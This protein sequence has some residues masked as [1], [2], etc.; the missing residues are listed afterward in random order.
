MTGWLLRRRVERALRMTLAVAGDCWIAPS[1]RV[2][3]DGL[4]PPVG[5]FVHEQF[6]GPVPRGWLVIPTCGTRLCVRP[7][8]LRAITRHERILKGDSVGG[9]N[10]R[11]R[12]CVAGHSLDLGDPNTYIT[13]DGRRR[14]RACRAACERTRKARM[15]EQVR[16]VS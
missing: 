8:H 9:R 12:R 10:S 11:K 16:T 7:E 6:A 14:C 3:R 13:P 5:R 15:R 2:C 1:T 4:T